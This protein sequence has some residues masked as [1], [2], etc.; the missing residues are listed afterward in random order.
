MNYADKKIPYAQI[1]KELI[2]FYK[3]GGK[4]FYYLN[5]EDGNQHFAKEK[6]SGCAGG[7]CS[8]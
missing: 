4:C 3:H 1:I 5:S 8:L 7:A 2:H 6:E